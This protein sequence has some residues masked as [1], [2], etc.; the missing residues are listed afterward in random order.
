M[1][2]LKPQEFCHELNSAAFFAFYFKYILNLDSDIDSILSQFNS[3]LPERIMID[4][5]LR[6][7]P[8][9]IAY[10]SF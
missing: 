1:N 5:T 7:W 4:A 9:I 6:V 8:K 2:V 3:Y 10:F